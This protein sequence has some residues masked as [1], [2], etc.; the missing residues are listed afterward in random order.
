MRAGWII[1]VVLGLVLVACGRGEDRSSTDRPSPSRTKTAD[2]GSTQPSGTSRTGARRRAPVD[3]PAAPQSKPSAAGGRGSS[4]T[5][6]RVHFVR[7]EQVESVV[8]H[9]AATPR[10]GGAA[11]DA[12]LAG[13]TPREAADE[14]ATWIPQRTR[15]RRLSVRGGTAS[16]DL[17][18]DFVADAD[19]FVAA[20]R[21]A[22]VTCTLTQFRTVDGV[23]FAVDGARVSAQTGG[24]ATVRR[25]VECLDYAGIVPT[26]AIGVRAGI[27]PIHDQAT[28]DAYTRGSDAAYR[29][30]GETARL[31]AVRYVGMRDVVA[32]NVSADSREAVVE[33]ARAT[34]EGGKPLDDPLPSMTVVLR[35]FGA[36]DDGP[37][38][39]TRATAPSIAV[40]TPAEGQ[41]IASP[42]RV[43]GAASAVEATV[44]VEVRQD[45]MRDHE[46]LG[47]GFVTASGSPE[48]GPFSGPIAF[49]QPTE[50]AGAI[51][52]FE[53]SG[54]TGGSP[55]I[56]ATVIRVTFAD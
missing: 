32:S 20:L 3:R 23:R 27:W 56:Q 25:P 51:V 33:I 39:V 7:G 4:R 17:T 1:I 26:A 6:V 38:T 54:A 21:F 11:L 13:P 47:S 18:R 44:Q 30:P 35:R 14:F 8:R 15:V 5:A 55:V 36:R 41:A 37:W 12:L 45:G 28:L 16:I 52:F 34:G 42:V 24:N 2:V 46:A 19:G 43:R 40:D 22:Q 48:L 49:G 31:F 10:I 29:D 50:P 9:V 53:A